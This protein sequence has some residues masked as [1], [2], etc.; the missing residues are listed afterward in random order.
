[1]EDVHPGQA[2]EPDWSAECWHVELAVSVFAETKRLWLMS[3][4]SGVEPA[5]LWPATS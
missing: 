4:I 3:V 2:R 5:R 1:V